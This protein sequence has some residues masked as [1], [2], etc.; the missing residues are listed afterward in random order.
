MTESAMFGVCPDIFI[1]KNAPQGAFFFDYFKTA[2]MRSKTFFLS[3]GLM[4]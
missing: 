3:R 1:K 2:L 4:M